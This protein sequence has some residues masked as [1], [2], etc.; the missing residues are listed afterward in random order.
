VK[1][2]ELAEYRVHKLKS[3]RNFVTISFAPNADQGGQ[4]HESNGSTE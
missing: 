2:S 1:W 3:N 4:G